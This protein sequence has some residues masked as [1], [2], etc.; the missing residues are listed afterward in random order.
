MCWYTKSSHFQCKFFKIQFKFKLVKIFSGNC[1]LTRPRL[2]S[3]KIMERY[4]W[5]YSWCSKVH[6][7]HWSKS[8]SLALNNL[9]QTFLGWS[10]FTEISLLRGEEDPD[11]SKTHLGN[12][13]ISKAEE[14][15]KVLV[16]TWNDQTSG[17][18]FM[19]EGQMG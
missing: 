12:L 5:N 16:L 10:V 17:K 15:V 11:G 19:K 8:F 4:S 18:T 9:I 14:G 1:W 3:N 6:L 13:L 7:H 2:C